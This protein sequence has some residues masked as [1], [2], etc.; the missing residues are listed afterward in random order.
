MGSDGMDGDDLKDGKA[1]WDEWSDWI[2]SE[3]ERLRGV[4]DVTHNHDLSSAAE[5]AIM[6]GTPDGALAQRRSFTAAAPPLVR[7]PPNFFR[8]F[9]VAWQEHY[10]QTHQR[11]T[12]LEIVQWH[13]ENADTMFPHPLDRPTSDE[14]VI[15]AGKLRRPSSSAGGSRRSSLQL[16]RPASMSPIARRSH[17]ARTVVATRMRSSL[18]PA[19]VAL[20]A[21]AAQ[22]AQHALPDV[23][24]DAPGEQGEQGAHA[25]RM[26]ASPIFPFAAADS[27]L[28]MT[29]MM[30]S[31]P[32]LRLPTADH[33]SGRTVVTTTA[34]CSS[35]LDQ[36]DFF[37][38]WPTGAGAGA[39]EPND[40]D[41]MM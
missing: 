35:D 14:L 37:E 4:P 25:A 40:A 19:G 6:I 22:H 36:N 20:H 34:P 12:T 3:N 9:N 18:G 39:H 23:F 38:G 8:P 30:S 41:W 27:Q 2:R 24:F 31:C 33:T 13:T 26:A 28:M 17:C 15:R 32:E 7:R 1:N 21:H 5:A 16:Q 11:M 29:L 10:A